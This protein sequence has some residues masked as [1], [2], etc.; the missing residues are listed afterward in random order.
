MRSFHRLRQVL[1]YGW[2]HAGQI[3]REAFEGKRRISLFFDILG[4]YSRYGMWSNQYLKERFWELDKEQ[5]HSIG[6]KCHETNLKKGAWLKDF[7]EN[8]D[9]FIKYGNVK[10]EKESLRAKRNEAYTKRYNAGRNLFVENDVNISR[11]HY[12]DGSISIGDN[13]L[14]AKHV[15]IDY[16]GEVVIDNN[17]KIANGV[18]IESHH[19]DLE[20]Y[21]HGEDVNVPTSLHICE[22]AYIGTRAIILDSCNYIG[23]YSRIG[24]GAVVTKDVPDYAVAVGVPAKVVKILNEV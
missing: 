19:R 18:C 17:V 1:K 9:F 24:A 21:K 22:G 8:R 11:Q 10:Y 6:A 20:A 7:Y 3:S 23:K 14:L 4:C 16:T 15:F 2:Q 12:L 5:R 13:V